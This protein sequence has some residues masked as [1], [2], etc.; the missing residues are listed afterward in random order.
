MDNDQ[1]FGRYQ[2]ENKRHIFDTF[3]QLSLKEEWLK[4]HYL[5]ALTKLMLGY[6]P[7]VIFLNHQ[8]QHAPLNQF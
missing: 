3:A 5:H 7:E 8:G 2:N 1:L 4:S 6:F